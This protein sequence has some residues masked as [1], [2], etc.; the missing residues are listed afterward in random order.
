MKWTKNK[1][2][3]KTLKDFQTTSL[4]ENSL[5]PHQPPMV[6]VLKRKAIRLFP[7]G[8][9]VALYHSDKLG[10]DVSIPYQSSGKSDT[11]KVVGSVKSE[12]Y[13]ELYKNYVNALKKH[14]EIGTRIDHP[15]LLKLKAE[16]I[17]RFGREAQK[18][19]HEAAEA[20]L[21]GLIVET[22]KAYTKF[23]N[24]IN[25][26]FVEI[27]DTKETLEE[28][29][30][31]QLHHMTK[32]KQDKEIVFGGG[33]RHHM[34]HKNAAH[35]M[36]LHSSVNPENKRK[37]ESLLNSPEGLTKVSDF[38]IANLAPQTAKPKT[39]GKK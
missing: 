6:L 35:I 19:L 29:V 2:T 26:N 9:S 38:A 16:C 33:K 22:A 25:E 37:I 28:A 32:A 7:S 21:N 8:E 20:Y 1:V 34:S 11:T 12:E 10:I 39:K 17:L 36:K 23:E 31:H 4:N 27:P 18:Y 5:T 30:I 14:Y 15:E 24:T 3:M 13:N